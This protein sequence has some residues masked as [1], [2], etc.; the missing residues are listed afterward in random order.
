MK[1]AAKAAA[2]ALLQ[3]AR[4]AER[5]LARAAGRIDIGGASGR[6]AAFSVR[7]AALVVGL[8]AIL[9][10][11]A[12]VLALRLDPSAGT[13]TLVSRDSAAFKATQ[14]FHRR[15]GDEP[16][17]VLIRGQLTDLLLTPDVA[18]ITGL[19]GCLS[20]NVPKGKPPKGARSRAL[21][22]ACAELAKSKPVQV[23]YGPGTF[24]TESARQINAEITSQRGG[25]AAQAADVAARAARRVAA[26]EG[27]STAEQE[28]LADQAR[29]VVNAQYARGALGLALR[30][31]LTS[32]PALNNPQ[33][34][35]RLVFEP[36]LGYS[37]P[38]SRFAY[39]FPSARSALIQARLRPGLSD[40]ERRRAIELVREAVKDPLFRLDRGSYVVSGVPTVT[41]GVASSVTGALR[42]LLI[43]A[44]AVM[45]ITLLLV[46]RARMRLL[47]LLLAL[48]ASALTFGV[49]SLAG[50]SL[51]IASI[52]VI[53]VLIGLAVDYAIQFQARFEEARRR[54]GEAAEPGKMGEPGEAAEP[55]EPGEAMVESG[56]ETARAAA[57]LGAPVIATAGLATAVGFLT[58]LLSPVPMVRSFGALLV[59]GIVL[60]FACTLTVG[61]ALMGRDF[62]V[63]RG[64]PIIA[65]GRRILARQTA[66]AKRLRRFRLG[67]PAR[68]ATA[69]RAVGR[70]VAPV[71]S[72]VLRGGRV[73]ASA[74]SKVAS[75]VRGAPPRTLANAI[76]RPRRV[77]LIAVV[78]AA[79][80]WALSS[81]TSVVSEVQRLV[82]SDLREVKD[83]KTLQDETGV[84]GD[85]NI[86]VRARDMTDPRVIGW[87]SN[88]QKR[89][90]ARHGYSAGRTCRQA[91]LC[92][93]VSLTNLFGSGVSQTPKR[94]RALLD[95]IP[96]YFS[97]A[98]ISK[99][100][101]TA[102]MSFGIRTMPLDDQKRLI[103]DMRAQLDPPR[104]VTAE[105]AGLPVLAADANAD[106]EASRW[107]LTLVGLA[108]VFLVL[109][110]IYR[111]TGRA[112]VPLIPIALAT[113]WSALLL[114]VLGV[115]LNPMSAT[116]GVLVIAIST[117][118]SVILSAR[119]RQE[120]AAGL[121]LAKALERTYER[122]GAAV[123][124]S[125]VTAIAGFGAL[126]FSDV[127]MLRDFGLV[128][129]V[130]LAVALTGT[131]VVLP[132][133][134]VW[135]E[136]RG[137][138][139]FPTRP[140]SFARRLRVL[141][142]RGEAQRP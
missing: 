80:G 141:R 5:S 116:L 60:A 122:T 24:I 43:A 101:R 98:V 123:L 57:R 14:E 29:Q 134:L 93:G 124:A 84:S 109:L 63:F 133:V 65:A 27:K 135:A 72:T 100:R 85:I 3:R 59:V 127:P 70:V 23:V 53:P 140:A 79:G 48:A 32:L 102:D 26:A 52:A 31:G 97:K 15:F 74:G 4:K 42:T 54:D 11:A 38:K 69:G 2:N 67:L 87:M 142:R 62:R 91:E 136:E 132:A 104:G 120:R 55:G 128:T 35:L 92:P 94:N 64:A 90:L 88:Y 40:D 86:L 41:E 139:V 75:L 37:T 46:F 81:Q 107:Q 56:A 1:S 61:S 6:V 103:D 76:Q 83:V 47:P 118:F 126:I 58:M 66:R 25:R 51:T 44:V 33:F 108:A 131:M 96:S 36:S 89:V 99:D 114:F 28:Q 106:L 95:A 138:I 10:G 73:V 18:S 17:V 8:V 16:I 30:Y 115:S 137:P 68:V 34:V 125:G 78:A 71:K 49:M 22:A 82:P 110:A 113:G 21:P 12:L 119:Y 112:L 20:G 111:S 50:A 117:E 129:V 7:R 9:C 19:E 105:L 77:L 121:A 39:L 130:D 13:G 45:A